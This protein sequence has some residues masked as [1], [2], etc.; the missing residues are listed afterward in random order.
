M[1][2]FILSDD[3]LN[4]TYGITVSE[5]IVLL[6]VTNNIELPTFTVNKELLDSLQSKMFIKISAENTITLREKGEA[7]INDFSIEDYDISSKTVKKTVKKSKRALNQDVINNIKN[8][9][10][11][12]KGLKPGSMGDPKACREKLSR[13]LDENPEYTMTEVIAAAKA[14]VRSVNDIRFLRR[15]DYFIYKKEQNGDEISTLSAII[16]D[17]DIQKQTE[18]WLNNFI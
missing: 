17:V 8:Y 5:F 13:W 4:Q 12:F 9:R 6:V 3:K 16:D 2:H 15:A 1:K 11:V 10:N 18:E 7:L 14:Y